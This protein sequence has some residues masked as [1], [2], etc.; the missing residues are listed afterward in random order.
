MPQNEL[1][2]FYNT[3]IDIYINL[4]KKTNDGFPIGV[5]AAKQGC[6]LLTTDIYNGNILNNFNID[7]Y[8]IIKDIND[9][10]NKIIELANNNNKLRLLSH[11]L[12]LKIYNLFNYNNY[13]K[14]IFTFITK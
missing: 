8:F 10:K 7:K 9:A 4:S 1:S 5:E 13:Q 14:K 12:Q 11:Q 2:I 6:I 3:K